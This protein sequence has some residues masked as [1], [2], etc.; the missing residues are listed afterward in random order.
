VLVCPIPSLAWEAFED[1]GNPTFLL[2]WS[3][4]NNENGVYKFPLTLGS[5][6]LAPEIVLWETRREER[7]VMIG[8]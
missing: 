7:E 3:V 4:S 6:G 2:S 8:C 5:F 1:I